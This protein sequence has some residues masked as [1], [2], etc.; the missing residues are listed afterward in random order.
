MQVQEMGLWSCYRS[1][2]F[3]GAQAPRVI[4]MMHEDLSLHRLDLDGDG[5]GDGPEAKGTLW[6]NLFISR[7]EMLSRAQT[8]LCV[9]LA[10]FG[11]WHVST[12]GVLKPILQA[13]AA[14]G[15]LQIDKCCP[16]SSEGNTSSPMR[17]RSI[18]AMKKT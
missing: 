5:D 7:A 10:D 16:T 11:T 18:P 4:A 12:T 15:L 8:H 14:E 13:A 9:I 2:D 1:R 3:F 17:K 6:R